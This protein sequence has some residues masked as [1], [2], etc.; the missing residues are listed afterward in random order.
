MTVLRCTAKRLE[1]LKQPA[2]TAE[3]VPQSNP[4]GEWYVDLN[5]WRRQS[6]SAGIRAAI[7]STTGRSI[8]FASG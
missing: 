4:L 7:W 3:Q 1:R 5:V 6:F 8:W 2:K